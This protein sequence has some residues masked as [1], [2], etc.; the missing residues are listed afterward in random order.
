VGPSD[1]AFGTNKLEEDVT[2]SI[3]A[4]SYNI[5]RIVS[6]MGGLAYSN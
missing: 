5:L 3:Y 6:G 1:A 2:L 4:I